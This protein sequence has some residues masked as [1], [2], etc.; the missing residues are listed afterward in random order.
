MTGLQASA[1]ISSMPDSVHDRGLIHSLSLLPIG[2]SNLVGKTCLV[3]RFVEDV[4]DERQGP[5]MG[6]S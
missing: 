6:G 2:K 1:L 3:K 4:F 5:T